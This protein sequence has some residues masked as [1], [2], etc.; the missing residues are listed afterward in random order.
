MTPPFL[1][2][3]GLDGTGKSTQCRRL[4]DW[5]TACGVRVVACADPGGTPLGA[6]L[7]E[8]LLSVRSDIG[9]RAEALLFMASRAEL[10]A[11]IIRP[12]L[13]AGCVVVS[14]RFILSNVVY[15]GHAGGLDPAELWRV[16][17]LSTGGLRPDLT[18][19]FDLPEE[20][21]AA[22]LGRDPDRMEAR[23]RDY[24]R[25]VRQG[26]LTEARAD[27]GCHRIIDAAGDAD[28]VTAAVWAAVRPLLLE[29]GYAV[30]EDEHGL[31]ARPRA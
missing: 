1:T 28:A 4:V 21:A 29:R 5:L 8:L 26:F 3:D 12:A 18:L 16:G 17:D 27:P 22:R 7:R 23:D 15:Q 11:K 20:V 14:D 19:V 10:V 31:A 25:R 6:T 30:T 13:A 9:L 24:R 2:L